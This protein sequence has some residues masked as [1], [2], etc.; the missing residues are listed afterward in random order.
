MWV[1]KTLDFAEDSSKEFEK[2][3]VSGLGSVNGTS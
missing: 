3:K 1:P 2:S